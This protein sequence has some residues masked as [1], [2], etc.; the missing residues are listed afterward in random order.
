MKR[1]VLALALGALTT[2]AFARDG[3][4]WYGTNRDRVVVSPSVTYLEPAP[5]PSDRVTVYYDEPAATAP[6]I[7]ERSYVTEPYVVVEPA[8]YEDSSLF[9]VEPRT[10]ANVYNGGLFPRR[11]PND[12]GQ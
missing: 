3:D 11:G 5:M 12:F 1:I 4:A 2:A 8:P 6:V 10:Y 9:R 7:V